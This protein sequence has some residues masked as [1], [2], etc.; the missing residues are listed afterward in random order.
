VVAREVL[1]EGGREDLAD[2]LLR[3]AGSETL[4]R[5]E[6]EERVAE[7]WP[8]TT[9]QS[10][11][12]GRRWPWTGTCPRSAALE[13]AAIGEL[14]AEGHHREAAC[15]LLQLRTAV[16]GILENDGDEEGAGL[17]AAGYGRLLAVAGDRGRRGLRRAREM[18]QAFVLDL[19]K[20][21]EEL[22]ARNPAALD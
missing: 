9:P 6:V 1:A 21:C 22:L 19:R 10:R 14:V 8:P 13:C 15:P 2:L 16:Q 5:A 3:L 12:G 17:V 11:R 4:S 20:G 7:L 18:L